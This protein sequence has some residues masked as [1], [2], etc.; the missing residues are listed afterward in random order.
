MNKKD[1]IKQVVWVDG[2]GLACYTM[3]MHSLQLL[4]DSGTNLDPIIAVNVE[5]LREQSTE[6]E[7][8]LSVFLK[9]NNYVVDPIVSHTYFHVA[10]AFLPLSR[11]LYV[12]E[13]AKGKLI[14]FDSVNNPVIEET[15]ELD[16]IVNSGGWR[17]KY[18][19]FNSEKEADAFKMSCSLALSLPNWKLR[20]RSIKAANRKTNV[21]LSKS[22]TQSCQY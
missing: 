21:L 22:T 1:T 4:V 10:V 2:P 5:S 18:V 14:E 13:T 6:H 17:V 20:F 9:N 8:E 3:S 15:I 19:L 16:Q 7:D 12:S 11:F